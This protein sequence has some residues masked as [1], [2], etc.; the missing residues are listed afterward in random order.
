MLLFLYV[1][2]ACDQYQQTESIK[3]EIK[4][5]SK[6]LNELKE[7]NNNF[8]ESLSKLS[9]RA[10]E[11]EKMKKESTKK[12]NDIN[13][14]KSKLNQKIDEAASTALYNNFRGMLKE[15]AALISL[16]EFKSD[17]EKKSIEFWDWLK[18]KILPT[19]YPQSY[20]LDKNGYWTIRGNKASFTFLS[21]QIYK[22]TKIEINQQKYVKC[23]IKEFNVNFTYHG[24]VVFESPIYNAK[25]ESQHPQQFYLN[26]SIW[27]RAFQL[28]VL[29]NNGEDFICLPSVRI[30]DDDYFGK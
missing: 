27:F 19:Y 13:E 17:V 25:E 30:L 24:N 5:L 7:K 26:H 3:T 2:S 29:K 11:I 14:T 12:I 15:R 8:R 22:A 16:I 9:E 6:A 28:N 18:A 1:F 21:D 20:P 23:G 4:G 10:K